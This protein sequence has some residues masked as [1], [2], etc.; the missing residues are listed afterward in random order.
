M[1]EFLY[2][3]VPCVV[4]LILESGWCE[5]NVD[6]IGTTLFESSGRER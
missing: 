2:R 5:E 4:G 6:E 3:S 1:G